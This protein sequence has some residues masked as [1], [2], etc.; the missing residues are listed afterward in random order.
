MTNNPR[1]GKSLHVKGYQSLMPEAEWQKLHP[2]IK[3]RFSIGYQKPVSYC[4]VM[5]EVSASLPGLI[6]ANVC[7][8]I[9]TPLAP[10][11]GKNVAMKVNVYP[12]P[13]LN[14]MTWDRFYF[15]NNRPISRISSTKSVQK[16]GSLAEM[17]GFGFGMNLK[18]SQQNGAIRFKSGHYF[19]KIFNLKI[20]IPSL[21]TPGVTKVTQTAIDQQR[22]EFKLEVNHPWFGQ[23]FKQVG[24]FEKR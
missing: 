14:G 23:V 6:F 10:Y 2:A 18:V 9:G 3:K 5:S 7:R 21:L 16:D 17:V 22:F 12:N 4:G 13:K 24:I 15:F 1:L 11:R 8:L 19:V 20:K